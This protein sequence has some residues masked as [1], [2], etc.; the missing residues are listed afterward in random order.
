MAAV[1]LPLQG[2]SSSAFCLFP[3]RPEMVYPLKVLDFDRSRP[4]IPTVFAK[5]HIAFR[6]VKW[7]AER[8]DKHIL[9]RRSSSVGDCEGRKVAVNGNNFVASFRVIESKPLGLY[10]THPPQQF[11]VKG[12]MRTSL[13]PR[14]RPRHRR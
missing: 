10:S 6:W 4:V 13:R 7:S 5:P 8:I 12:E 3:L 9:A 11:G 2:W 1:Q 14:A